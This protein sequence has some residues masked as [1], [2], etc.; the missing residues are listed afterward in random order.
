MA[1]VYKV[2]A[3]VNMKIWRKMMNGEPDAEE[4]NAKNDAEDDDKEEEEEED[5]DGDDVK[6]KKMRC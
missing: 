2:D 1:V 4:K 3:S 6:M 5:Q